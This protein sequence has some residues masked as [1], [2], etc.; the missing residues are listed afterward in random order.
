MNAKLLTRSA[1]IAL[2][3]APG[4]V[5][6]L[7]TPLGEYHW[8]PGWDPEFIYP[9]S[10]EAGAN[11]VFATRHGDQPRTIWLTVTYDTDQHRAEYVNFTPDSH[12]SRITI[13]CQPDGAARTQAE[14]NYT[15][16][17]TGPHGL[18]ELAKL[19]AEAFASRM[20]HW[21]HA[22]NYYLE[23]GEANPHLHWQAQH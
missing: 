15:L 17:A 21:Q 16:V 8:V 13:Q 1:V 22:I 4:Q 19:S 9:P 12:L 2:N 10:G 3:G 23:H 6:P 18:V 20:Q 7:F 11:T 5:F 14:V